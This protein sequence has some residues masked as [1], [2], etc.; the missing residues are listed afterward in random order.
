M[1]SEAITEK[2]SSKQIDLM[3]SEGWQKGGGYIEAGSDTIY[4]VIR[5]ALGE[6]RGA[7]IG[8]NGTIELTC[9]FLYNQEKEIDTNRL[10]ILECNAGVFFDRSTGFLD[11]HAEYRQA[12]ENADILACGW[13]QP[14]G[15][16]EIQHLEK[17][18]PG[19]HKIPLRA[20]EP[21]YSVS[22]SWLRA[23]ENQHVAVVSSFT[24]SIKDQ[25]DF[26]DRIWRS[27]PLLFPEVVE[28]SFIRSY[29]SPVLA[30]GKCQWPKG[31]TSWKKAVD[32]LEERVLKTGARI[33]L[34]GCGGLGMP[35]ANRLKSKGIIAIVLGGAIQIL[36]GIK[37]KRW[38]NHATISE[39]FN[40][41][42]VYPKSEEIPNG[43]TLVEGGCY[44]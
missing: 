10:K 42:W 3:V 36:F 7:L 29:Y 43:S 31:I 27:R 22:D 11:W 44:W 34:I 41:D 30:Q 5:R 17:H 6:G 24:E 18:N 19:A 15:R 12:L 16:A 2:L 38:E 39:F 14:L 35:L 1:E 37:G 13:Y 21:Y 20:L 28:W 26:L 33:C 25:I 23:F 32:D 40:S 4:A 9:F 8:R